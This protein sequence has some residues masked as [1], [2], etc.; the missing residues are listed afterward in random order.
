MIEAKKRFGQNFLKDESITEQIIQ[1]MPNDAR[2]IVE[3][4]PGL[5]DLTRKL[6]SHGR[7][8]AAFEIDL[9]LC[10][11]LKKAF[12]AEIAEE[13][14]HLICDDV[15]RRWEGESLIEEPYHLVANLP[16]YIATNIVLRALDD[17]YCRSS[18]VMVQKEVAQKFAARP[19]ERRFGALSV[20][21]GSVA[22]VE[23]LFE[24]PPEAF[25]PPPKV[26]SAV[27]KIA[28]YER[29]ERL[30]SEAFREFLRRA[31]SAPRKTLMKN[32]SKSYA[33]ERLVS[34]FQTL[35]LSPQARAHQLSVKD[36]HLLFTYLQ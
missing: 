16:Y 10:R 2:R 25:E 22:D 20:L 29:S 3:I 18:I 36:Y 4:G 32:L 15:L 5:G 27:L 19:G 23:L 7:E 31:F 14:L 13:R 8:I 33:K 28:K 9:E 35:G 1:S 12:S 24:V 26:T 6:L 30:P 21:S 17:P 11:H 34:A